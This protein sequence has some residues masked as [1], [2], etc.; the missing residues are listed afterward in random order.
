MESILVLVFFGLEHNSRVTGDAPVF[1][2][3]ERIRSVPA[4]TGIFARPS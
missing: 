3:I 2:A 1:L 4:E